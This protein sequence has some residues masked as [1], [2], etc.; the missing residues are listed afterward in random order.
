IV[1]L[2]ALVSIADLSWRDPRAWL[3]VAAVVASAPAQVTLLSGQPAGPA[4]AC[5]VLGLWLILRRNRELAGGVLL[6]IA[7][8]F[9]LQLGAPFL[10]Y[11]LLLRPRPRVV[12]PGAIL[13]LLIAV[14]GIAPMQ[15]QHHPW[16]DQWRQ[17]VQLTVEP[18][19][20]N[21]PTFGARFR[22]EML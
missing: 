16:L 22:F 8:A 6:G 1:A 2:V 12:L 9:K 21:D 20:V 4:F 5:I 19:G 3:L 10:A 18:G 11:Y 17:Q 15:L 14:I 13:L 7:A